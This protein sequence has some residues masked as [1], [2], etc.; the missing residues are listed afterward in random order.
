MIIHT[1]ITASS[2]PFR[3]AKL[4]CKNLAT[5][6]A[7]IREITNSGMAGWAFDALMHKKTTAVFL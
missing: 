6:A 1:Y 2:L 7:D 4:N 3:R 5:V